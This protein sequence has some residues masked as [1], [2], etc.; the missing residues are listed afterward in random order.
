MIYDIFVPYLASIHDHDAGCT[1]GK[2]NGTNK[3]I[4]ISPTGTKDVSR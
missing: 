3:V 2:M 4:Q 1:G